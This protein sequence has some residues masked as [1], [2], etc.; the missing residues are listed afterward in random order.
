MIQERRQD[1]V[2]WRQLPLVD[3]LAKP[4]CEIAGQPER[5]RLSIEWRRAQERFTGA[6][7]LDVILQDALIEIVH[8]DIAP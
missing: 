8:A 4:I 6:P 1:D 5:N 2:G 7:R 3:D